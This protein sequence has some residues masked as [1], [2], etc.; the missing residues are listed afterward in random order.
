MTGEGEPESLIGLIGRLAEPPPP[1]P[2]PMLPQTAG[3]AVAAALLA[4]ALALLAWVLA[5]RRQRNAYRRAALAALRTA[6]DD[7]AEIAAI[8]RRAA[9]AAFP[10]AE[11]AGLAGRDWIG[12][13]E[14]TGR[15]AWPQ[16]AAAALLAG[17][18]QPHPAPAPDL[19]RAASRWIRRHRPGARR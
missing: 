13:L 12:F 11:V 17:P 8:L 2:V 3:W 4:G 18:W 7:P 10:R 9:L 16:R 6:G 14:A 19:A 1:D 15:A 5:R